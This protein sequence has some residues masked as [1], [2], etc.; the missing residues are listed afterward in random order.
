[1][2]SGKFIETADTKV[3]EDLRKLGF[4]E[5][6]QNGVFFVFV[7]VGRLNFDTKKVRYTDNLTI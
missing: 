2:N 4:P 1:M 3:A 7:N 6:P 5:L